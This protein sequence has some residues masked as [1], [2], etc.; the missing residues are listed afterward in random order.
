M[1][2]NETQYQITQRHVEN[3]RAALTALEQAPPADPLNYQNQRGGISSMLEALQREI[4]LWE[5][6]IREPVPGNPER[7]DLGVTVEQHNAMTDAEDAAF[8]LRLAV[9]S[10]QAE[11][12]NIDRQI[13]IALDRIAD[14]RRHRAWLEREIAD[15]AAADRQPATSDAGR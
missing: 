11:I 1:I 5:A 6:G 2:A 9:V 4:A 10:K 7:P 8:S 13:G 3:F 12:A 14:W 15:L